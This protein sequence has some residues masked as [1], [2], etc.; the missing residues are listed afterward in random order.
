MHYT[1][2]DL[3]PYPAMIKDKSLVYD[4]VA[5]EQLMDQTHP[6]TDK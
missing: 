3:K 5:Y 6:R 2:P 4:E 1:R